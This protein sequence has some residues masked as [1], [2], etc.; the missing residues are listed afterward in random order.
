M[1]ITRL[2][3]IFATIDEPIVAGGAH[4]RFVDVGL[5]GV[6]DRWLCCVLYKKYLFL[7]SSVSDY[8]L[9]T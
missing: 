3:E 2:V 9:A 7:S 8:T 1:A 4:E 6:R 5:P